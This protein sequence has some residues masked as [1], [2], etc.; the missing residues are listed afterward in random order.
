MTTRYPS[1]SRPLAAV[2]ERSAGFSLIELMVSIGISMVLIAGLAAMLVNVSHNNNEMAKSNS[3][4]ENG[5]FAIQALEMDLNQA[6]FWGT[7]V[8]QFDDTTWTG[9][10]ADAPAG[11]I[12]DP[13]VA[14]SESTWDYAYINNVI[15]VPVV[16]R[17]TMFANCTSLTNQVPDTAVLLVRHAETCEAGAPGCDDVVDDMMYFQ[18]SLCATATR[19]MARATGNSASTIALPSAA[20]G[21][22]T[23]TLNHAY[24]GMRIHLTGGAGA[25][26]SRTISDYDGPTTTATVSPNWGTTPNGTTAFTISEAILAT[27]GFTNKKR[28]A[29]CKTADAAEL[30]KFV[31][32]I[33]YVRDFAVTAGDGIPTLVRS[34]F[35]RSGTTLTHQ[36]PEALVE[37]I[38]NFQVDVG[39]DNKVARC[40]LGTDVN[41]ANAAELVSPST[42]TTSLT[43]PDLNTLPKNR[44]DGAPDEYLRCTSTSA[45]TAAQLANAVSV[46]LYLL[47]RNNE[48]TQGYTD[49]KTYCMG[50]STG[51][52]PTASLVGPMDDGFQRHLFTTSVRLTSIAGR[53]ETP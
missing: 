1:P 38:E 2:P 41:Y 43:N 30:R 7:F 46:K 47:V 4:I 51:T 42:C 28:S 34:R 45:C 8:P 10:P 12:G 18:S 13:C 50:A 16:V 35:D 36:A 9:V 48:P 17:D 15:G 21:V 52:C 24:V 44:G 14:H 20:A 53:R 32:N 6:G 11:T 22:T 39:L 37:G 33:Y 26:Q 40:A 5:R 29:N 23:S 49:T 31:S 27:S 19:G 25:G 3:Q